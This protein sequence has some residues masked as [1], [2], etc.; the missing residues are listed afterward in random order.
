MKIQ[1]KNIREYSGIH[2]I[3]EHFLSWTIPVIQYF[4]AMYYGPILSWNSQFFCSILV[5]IV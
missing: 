2:K 3:R 4:L 5:G 1:Q